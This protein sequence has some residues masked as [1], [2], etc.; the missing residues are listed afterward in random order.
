M[1][2]NKLLIPH[3]T[4]LRDRLIA[5][6][7]QSIGHLLTPAR[8]RTEPSVGGV[9]E[10]LDNSL[11]LERSEELTM[12]ARDVARLRPV[13]AAGEGAVVDFV[14]ARGGAD[15]GELFSGEG[16][17]GTVYVGGHDTG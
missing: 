10:R 2:L 17:E 7:Q 12:L 14:E 6:L 11:L 13:D 1:P 8:C 9:D 4:K 5:G 15:G 3:P 16:V